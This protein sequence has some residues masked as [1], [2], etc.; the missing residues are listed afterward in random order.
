MVYLS[1]NDVPQPQFDLAFGLLNTNPSRRFTVW[2]ISV[3]STI[4]K[5]L[6][7]TNT[8]TPFDS[9]TLSQELGFT[10]MVRGIYMNPEH[11]PALT[12]KRTPASRLL[13]WTLSN[14]ILIRFAASGVT[15]IMAIPC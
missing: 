2:S 10:A 8:L 4:T 3:P 13:G 5:L 6:G 9:K 7:S 14:I 12:A 1:S 11:P 15:V